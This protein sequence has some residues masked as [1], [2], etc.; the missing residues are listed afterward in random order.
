MSDHRIAAL[1]LL[2]ELL[3]GPALCV[4]LIWLY[5]HAIGGRDG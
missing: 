2:A 4:G 3:A 5:L 1:V